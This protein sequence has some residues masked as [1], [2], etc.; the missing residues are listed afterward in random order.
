MPV[1]T[2]EVYFC[3]PIFYFLL[4]CIFPLV[5]F[6]IIKQ[7]LDIE[8]ISHQ[9]HVIKVHILV[10]LFSLYCSPYEP[11]VTVLEIDKRKI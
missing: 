1:L 2:F 11:T 9:S 7:E 3:F 5:A 4:N 10:S 6:N 8:E